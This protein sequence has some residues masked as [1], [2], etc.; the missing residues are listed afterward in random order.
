LFV[1]KTHILNDIGKNYNIK[2][3]CNQLKEKFGTLRVYSSA[4]KIED[5]KDFKPG[6]E[7][8]EKMFD[9]A[10]KQCEDDCLHVC[11]RCGASG[12][13]N[14]E[15]IIETSGWIS[16]ICKKCAREITENETKHYDE[17]HKE[18]E[19]YGIDRITL[20][21][22]ENQF[23]NLYYV[24]S[25]EYLDKTYNSIPHA[26]FSIVDPKNAEVYDIISK[27]KNQ[28]SACLIEY[29]A[30]KFGFKID[31]FELLKEIVKARFFD[32]WNN[33]NRQDLLLTKNKMLIKMNNKHDNILGYC[34]CSECKNI[35]KQNI[36]GKILMEVRDELK[37]NINEVFFDLNDAIEFCTNL[38]LDLNLYEA[39]E[40]SLPYIKKYIVSNENHVLKDGWTL[41]LLENNLK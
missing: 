12:G 23:L 8:L 1:Q 3:V 40:N 2:F 10:L 38:N 35:E 22:E 19:F 6:F 26:Y 32:K 18:N 25:F 7:I 28:Y 5:E 4:K 15:N 17:N 21:K 20:F 33:I 13:V 41:T 11:E 24:H 27:S 34:Y 14:N 29:L 39:V 31:D 36:Y 37:E 16:Y 9:D 30:N